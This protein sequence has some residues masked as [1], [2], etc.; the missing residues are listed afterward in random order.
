MTR[1]A[2]KISV[3]HNLISDYWI[4]NVFFFSYV[5]RRKQDYVDMSSVVDTYLLSDTTKRA[6]ILNEQFQ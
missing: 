5:K 6:N 2:E 1:R 3:S 4:Q